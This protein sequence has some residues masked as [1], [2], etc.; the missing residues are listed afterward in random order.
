[1]AGSSKMFVYLPSIRKKTW[2]LWSKRSETVRLREY[3]ADKCLI[4]KS[5]SLENANS[6]LAKSGNHKE[7]D[8]CFNTIRSDKVSFW[9]QLSNSLNIRD[10]YVTVD[11]KD[12]LQAAFKVQCLRPL[13]D[14]ETTQLQALFAQ[15]LSLFGKI[16]NKEERLNDYDHKDTTGLFKPGDG[17]SWQSLLLETSRRNGKVCF[18]ETLTNGERNRSTDFSLA[19]MELTL[20]IS[21]KDNPFFPNSQSRIAPDG[22]GVRGDG[23]L[24]VLEVKGPSDEK[25]LLGPLLQATCGALAV[26]AAKANLCQILR[27]STGRRPKYANAR[28]PKKPSVGIHI[29]TAKKKKSGKLESWS[30]THETLCNRVLHAFPQLQYIAYSFV[31]PD[32]TENFNKLKVDHLITRN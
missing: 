18:V 7:T 14:G 12:K 17:K 25:D 21:A 11:D 23:F 10:G 16:K 32:E 26:V 19:A 9:F 30:D 20:A 28:V 27:S 29:L 3:T 13:V 8:A 24:T 22:L 2:L 5:L 31:V 15:W 4:V 1:M 6:L